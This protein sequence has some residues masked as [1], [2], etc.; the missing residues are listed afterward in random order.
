MD[1]NVIYVCWLGTL[2][3]NFAWKFNC[4]CPLKINHCISW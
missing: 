2:A 3:S 1:V 4:S